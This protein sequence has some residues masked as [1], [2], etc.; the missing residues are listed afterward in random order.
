MTVCMR[1]SRGGGGGQGVRTP[2]KNHKNIGFL[3]NTCLDPLKIAKPPSQHSMLCNHQHASETPFKWRLAG[4]P[5]MAPL[6]EVFGSS[7]PS[8][9]NKCCQSLA[10][11]EKLSGSACGCVLCL[12]LAVPY[13]SL[14]SMIVAF[15]RHTHSFF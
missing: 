4:G 14:Q 8:T 13:V 7:L 5:M 1:R 10:P 15:P 12:F 6:I 9:K 2:L 11:S 3:N